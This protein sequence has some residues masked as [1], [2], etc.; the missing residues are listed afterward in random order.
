M[1]RLLIG[2]CVL[3][4][5]VFAVRAADDDTKPQKPKAIFMELVQ[6]YRAAKTQAE[7]GALLETYSQKLLTYAEKHSKEADAIEALVMVIQQLPPN[8]KGNPQAKA[9]VSIKKNFVDNKEAPKAARAQACGIY[10]GAQENI[11]TS[12]KDAKAV[13]A[14]KKEMEEIRKLA[15]DEL[16]GLV[17]D[18][19]VGATMPELKSKDLAGKEVKLSDLKGKV[20]VLDI[21][22]TWC[23]PC[24]AMIPHSRELVKKLK[25]KP[26]VLVSISADAKKETL[27]DFMEKEAM[28]WTHWWNGAAGGILSDLDVKFFPTIYV[29]D[30]KGVIRF[31]GVRENAMDAA[32]ETLLKEI[33]DKTKPG[34]R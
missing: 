23:G 32:V 31:K 2:T 29:L 4:L 8:I 7:R 18:V 24:R 26:F 27:T 21:W 34:T 25:D 6:K 10:M 11:V 14:A 9:M 22:A 20:V 33:E 28:P 17:K 3:A 12:S 30:A 1:H 5:A 19:Y 16:K 13:A 15:K